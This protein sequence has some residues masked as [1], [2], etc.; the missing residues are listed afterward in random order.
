MISGGLKK[1]ASTKKGWSFMKTGA[2]SLNTDLY[3]I[4]YKN[5]IDPDDPESMRRL[6]YMDPE[7]P[8]EVHTFEETGKSMDDLLKTAEDTLSQGRIIGLYAAGEDAPRLL[9]DVKRESPRKNGGIYDSVALSSEPVTAHTNEKPPAGPTFWDR[10]VDFFTGGTR[11]QKKA[12]AQRRYEKERKLAAWTVKNEKN[13]H[14]SRN[15]AAKAEQ[16]LAQQ[17]VKERQKE[18]Q[19][20]H[21]RKNARTLSNR[22]IITQRT[23]SIFGPNADPPK[24]IT[25]AD[26]IRKAVVPVPDGMT[27]ED[28]TTLIEAACLSEAAML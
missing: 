12:A 14:P 27:E 3:Q 4:F 26:E 28:C 7:K 5:G 11:Y 6:V 19:V 10:I 22:E 9:K 24:D 18:Q 17:A 23:K 25:H 2:G 20:F 8:D 16:L 15:A 21:D 1:P 13:L